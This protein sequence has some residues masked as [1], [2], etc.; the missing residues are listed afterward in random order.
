M[1]GLTGF[2]L[3]CNAE[4]D[5]WEI[6]GTLDAVDWVMGQGISKANGWDLLQ[7]NLLTSLDNLVQVC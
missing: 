7:E 1:L 5:R 4:C 6:G 2:L 3:W